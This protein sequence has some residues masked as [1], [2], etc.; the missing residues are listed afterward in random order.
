MARRSTFPRSSVLILG[1]NS[2]H[3]LLPA[4]L[5]SQAESLLESH[6]LDDVVELADQQRKKL[7][8]KL[9]VDEDEVR[10]WPFRSSMNPRRCD[11]F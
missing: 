1:I 10:V 6:R 3:S 2:L 8:G 11:A 4:T 7:Q 5:I 9:T